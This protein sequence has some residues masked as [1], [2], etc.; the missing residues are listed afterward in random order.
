MKCRKFI[1]IWI[2]LITQIQQGNCNHIYKEKDYQRY[3]CKAHY[4]ETEVVLDDKTRIDCLTNEYAIE[5]DFANKW[6]EA[7]GQSL[8]YAHKTNKKAGIVLIIENYEQEKKYL[9]R[10]ISIAKRYNISVWTISPN[11][12]CIHD[13]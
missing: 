8:Y 9:E 6:A 3:W 12:L 7:I 2:I 5:F 10:L 1:I 13:P 11:I 4:G